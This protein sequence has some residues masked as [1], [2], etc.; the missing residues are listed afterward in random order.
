MNT[1]GGMVGFELAFIYATKVANFFFSRALL[2]S[3]SE[4]QL[5]VMCTATIIFN[6]L[7]KID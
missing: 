7:E 4:Q 3:T 2:E 5:T 1:L 6:S